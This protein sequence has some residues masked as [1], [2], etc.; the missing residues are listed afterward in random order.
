M[1]QTTLLPEILALRPAWDRLKR[2]VWVFDQSRL[3]TLYANPAGLQLWNAASLEDLV[4]RDF[5]DQ[6][7]AARTRGERLLALTANGEQVVERWTFYPNGQPMTVDTVISSLRF[8]DGHTAMLFEGQ[9]VE[10]LSDERRAVEALRHTSAAISLFDA[11]GAAI[12]GNPAAWRAYG[13][14]PSFIERFLDRRQG[15]A[16]LANAR[17]RQL[18]SGVCEVA[19]I[20]GHRW[21]Q[22]N[23][24]PAPDPATGILGVLLNE[25][26]VTER[27][28]AEA[29]RAAAEQVAAM[30]AERQTFLS[31]MSHELRTPLNA[32]LGF[33]EMLGRAELTP[34]QVDQ[35]RRINAAGRE[36]SDVVE[37]LIDLSARH[38]WSAQTAT[39]DAGDLNIIGQDKAVLR[40]LHVLCADDNDNNRML[41]TALLATQGMICEAVNDG[42]GALS[43]AAQG[44]W[45]VVLMDVQMPIM[46]GVEA[47]R[48]IRELGGGNGAV[49]IIAVTANTLDSQ[50]RSYIEAGMDDVVA[51]PVSLVELMTKIAALTSIAQSSAASK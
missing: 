33:S 7:E 39:P 36:L 20:A 49:P 17:S 29:A 32:V 6:S 31:E 22:I 12:F 15:E 42:A 4:A 24:R 10:F 23:V 48:R 18:W 44:G 16:A 13:E 38:D 21:H 45:D 14:A 27:V 43:A 26:D 3:Q 30:A 11:E 1:G 5:S 28:E 8:A 9:T 19:T 34:D 37:Q 46:D 51:K 25:I 47:S 2:P 35:A 50:I 41:L 40:P